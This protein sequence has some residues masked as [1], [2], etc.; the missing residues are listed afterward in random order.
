MLLFWIICVLMILLA[1]WFVLPPLF[2]RTESRKSDELRAANVLI[3]Q[4]QYQELE[5]DLRNGLIGEPEQQKE[6]VE[7][8][9]RLLADI[10]AAKSTSSSSSVTSPAIKKVAYAVGAAIPIVAIAFY[11]ARGNPKAFSPQTAPNTM[12][13][14]ASQSGEMTPQQIQANV[15]KLAKRLEENPNDVQGWTMLGRSYTMMER[16]SDAANAYAR[17]TAL[18]ANDASLWADFAE[19]QALAN[20]QRIAGKPLEAVDRALQL[21]PKNEKAL[22]LAG[23]AAFEARDYKKAI[24]YWQKLPPGSEIRQDVSEQLAKAKELAGGPGSR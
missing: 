2:A 1:L 14:A 12:P 4:D 5:T 17:A 24:E 11:L 9:R 20:G 15:G 23:S 19:A 7:L 21:D 10:E 3:Y 13:A 8:E 22:A 6:K 18:N 16:Y